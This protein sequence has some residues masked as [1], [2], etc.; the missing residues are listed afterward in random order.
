LAA[1]L[2]TALQHVERTTPVIVAGNPDSAE[3]LKAAG[4]A[5]FV[6][7]RTNPLEFLTRWQQQLGIEA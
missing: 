3:E 5:D 4:V 1:A 7:I 6:H 2:L